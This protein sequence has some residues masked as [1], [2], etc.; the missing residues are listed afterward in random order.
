MIYRYI[1]SPTLNTHLSRSLSPLSLSTD[2]RPIIW[3]WMLLLSLLGA[4]A[5]CSNYVE[6]PAYLTVPNYI[7]LPGGNINKLYGA[8]DLRFT[9]TANTTTMTNVNASIVLCSENMD[10]VFAVTAWNFS[11]FSNQI[12]NATQ[13][14]SVPVCDIEE[15]MCLYDYPSAGC[16]TS[17]V[18]L[19][20]ANLWSLAEAPQ[21][22]II[23]SAN[24]VVGRFKING[25]QDH[26][27][28]PTP[29]T[30]E[31]ITEIAAPTT[32][33]P[34]TTAAPTIASN[35]TTA[36]PTTTAPTT[37]SNATTTAPTTAAPTTE[38]PTT[39]APTTEAPTTAVPTTEAPT[40]EAPTTAAPTTAAPTSPP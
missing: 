21:V 15:G 9:T 13:S 26:R 25:T 36:P 10:L 33:A 17:F 37:A 4:K 3:T 39:A 29:S 5:S 38:A 8:I 18:S 14:F 40:T 27:E 34:P 30:Y 7:E 20:D 31:E 28:A 32:T 23:A 11:S 2:M 24:I 19:P 16:L 1:A 35:A 6:S 22:Y 12:I